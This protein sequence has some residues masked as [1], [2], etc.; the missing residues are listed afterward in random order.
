MKFCSDPW[1]EPVSDLLKKHLHFQGSFLSDAYSSM[2]KQFDG[3]INQANVPDV[4]V[5]ELSFFAPAIS[6]RMVR[7]G[8]DL[9]AWFHN[10]K[11]KT[12]M[13]LAMDPLRK[14][15]DYRGSGSSND[16]ADVNTPFSLHTQ[17][18]NDYYP[19]VL[20]ALEKYNV[21]VTD[22]FKLY[23][24][25]GEKAISNRNAVF[26][27]LKIHRDIL[28][29]EIEVVKPDVV[30]TLGNHALSGVSK[31]YAEFKLK[32]KISEKLFRYDFD[33]V[34]YFAIPHLSGAARGG[35]KKFILTNYHG[36]RIYSNSNYG[37]DALELIEAHLQKS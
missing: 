33:G 9:P 29:S 7:Y 8:I 24:T 13:V 28:R 21:Y 22:I 32:G 18:E 5:T 34:S 10:G 16:V 35:A 37:K 4:P 27:S 6:D 1:I 25:D 26:T 36:K 11:R 19:F 3:E 30:L 23:S 17:P 2:K 14:P 15:N 20:M 31:L 12:L